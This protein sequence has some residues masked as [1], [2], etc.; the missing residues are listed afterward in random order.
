VEDRVPF[1]PVGEMTFDDASTTDG[2][3]VGYSFTAPVFVP[4]P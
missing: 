1:H 2:Q 4:V 3:P